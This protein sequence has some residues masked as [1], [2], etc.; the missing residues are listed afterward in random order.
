MGVVV[1][2]ART[3]TPV[4]FNRE[5]RRLVADLGRP[6]QSPEEFLD[7]L[8]IRRA[9]G[10]ETA[11]PELPLARLMSAGE[12]VRAEEMTLLAPGGG[13][14]TTLVNATPIISDGG[15]VETYVVTLQD[16]TELEEVGTAAGRLPGEGEP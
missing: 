9:D 13:S 14:V 11:L 7:T 4:S 1:F 16:L 6:G 3:G 15:E 8:T 12:T 10:Q 2:D 5:A